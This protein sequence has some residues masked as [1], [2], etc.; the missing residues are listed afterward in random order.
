MTLF[1]HVC[2]ARVA[3]IGVQL[4]ATRFLRPCALNMTSFAGRIIMNVLCIFS[5]K[6]GVFLFYPLYRVA[7]YII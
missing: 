5:F 6:E 1:V 2:R 3:N 4:H 7:F